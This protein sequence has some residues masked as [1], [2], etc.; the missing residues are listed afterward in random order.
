MR[1]FALL[2][3]VSTVV[4]LAGAY[5][6]TGQLPGEFFSATAAL[7][8]VISISASLALTAFAFGLITN[9]Y[10]WVDRL[11]STAPVLYGWIYAWKSGFSAA[12]VF[13]A[14]LVS[15]WGARLTFNFARK[16]GYTGTEDYRWPVLRERIGNPV[17]W[18]LFNLLFISVFQI[19]LFVLFTSPFVRL[20]GPAEYPVLFYLSGGLLLAFLTLETAADQQQWVFFK[21]KARVREQHSVVT[22]AEH[23]AEISRGFLSSGLFALVRH[24]NYLG[25][26]GVWWSFFLLGA[27]HGGYL[28]HWSLTGPVVL[29]LLFYGSTRFT[30]E[31]SASKYPEYRDYQARVPAIV[32][33]KIGQGKAQEE[34]A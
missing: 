18:Q 4:L 16:G 12:A 32:P 24:P 6:V 26:L 8:I 19:G 34:E 22:T 11:W 20:G 14:L 2:L 9:D 33:L 17:L 23:Q 10:S 27:A 13:G 7:D 25:E 5:F 21:A 31:I 1:K 3:L 30:E 28:L 29:S 15:A